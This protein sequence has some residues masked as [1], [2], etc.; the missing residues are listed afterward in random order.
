MK[1]HDQEQM[2]SLYDQWQAS[3]KSK[4]DFAINHGIRPTT[5]YYWARKFERAGSGL[6]PGFRRISIEETS[7][8]TGEL[9][10]SIHYPSG[11]RVDLYTSIQGCMG[12]S[13]IEL[14]KKLTG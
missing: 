8:T 10:A 4:I 2:L 12:S 5:F 13:S 1:R 11:I 3:G 14:L 7:F 9:M 6:A